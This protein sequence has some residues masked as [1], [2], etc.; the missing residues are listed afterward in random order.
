MT[1]LR[2][3]KIDFFFSAFFSCSKLSWCPPFFC[4]TCLSSICLPIQ[5]GGFV[6][7][8]SNFCFF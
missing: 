1:K 8:I 3:C 4:W 2:W 5:K 7:L 6:S